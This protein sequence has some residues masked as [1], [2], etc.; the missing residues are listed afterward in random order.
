MDVGS[1]GM[2]AER[3]EGKA[4]RGGTYRSLHSS[5]F[6][7]GPRLDLTYIVTSTLAALCTCQQLDQGQ[8][9]RDNERR[10]QQR[11][12]RQNRLDEQRMEQQRTWDAQKMEHQAAEQKTKDNADDAPQCFRPTLGFMSTLQLA[13]RGQHP[14]QY[15]QQL[16][17]LLLRLPLLPRHNPEA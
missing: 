7:C 8:P 14:P 10:E 11:L 17:Y 6:H 12:E 4:R 9:K 15:L 2:V 1:Q 13:L 16:L 3:R 5:Q